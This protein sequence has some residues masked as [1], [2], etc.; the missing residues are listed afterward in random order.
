MPL[1]TALEAL[2]CKLVVAIGNNQTGRCPNLVA[3]ALPSAMKWTIGS[4]EA[5]DGSEARAL[6][7]FLV[8][9]PAGRVAAAYL[10]GDRAAIPAPFL[11]DLVSR[12]QSGASLSGSPSAASAVDTA[13]G[14]VD[15]FA[16]SE[17]RA[18]TLLSKARSLDMLVDHAFG[19]RERA[20]EGDCVGRHVGDATRRRGTCSKRAFKPRASLTFETTLLSRTPIGVT[21]A[22]CGPN[23]S[24]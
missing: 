4:L 19:V 5:A 12:A 16:Y 20:V 14:C 3:G 15:W 22:G 11:L 8:V 21:S 17:T 13:L 24:Y 1:S 6:T 18:G 10:A 7:I 2:T 23:P 9:D